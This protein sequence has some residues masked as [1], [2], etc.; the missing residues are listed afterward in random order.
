MS[1]W[2][3][4]Q[5]L[6]VGESCHFCFHSALLTFEML[7]LQSPREF[8]LIL[9]HSTGHW[10]SQQLV[11]LTCSEPCSSPADES[12]GEENTLLITSSHTLFHPVFLNSFLFSLMS[13]TLSLQCRQRIVLASC[14]N[15]FSSANPQG[16][17]LVPLPEYIISYSFF[18]VRLYKKVTTRH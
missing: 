16:C 7:M 11:G 5:L 6:S 1:V 14:R 15:V 4:L 2:P 3:S 17:L 10:L 13:H 18:T 8:S 9:G 12:L